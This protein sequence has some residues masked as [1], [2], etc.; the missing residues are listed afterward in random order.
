[1]KSEIREQ[2]EEALSEWIETLSFHELST[3]EAL[4]RAFEQ[5]EKIAFSLVK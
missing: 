1:M 5:F 4:L 3:N 2:L